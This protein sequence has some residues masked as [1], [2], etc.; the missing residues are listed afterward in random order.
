MIT[1]VFFSGYIC[2]LAFTITQVWVK[3]RHFDISYLYNTSTYGLGAPGSSPGTGRF[4]PIT[5]FSNNKNLA[6]K[7]LLE[8][9]CFPS[10]KN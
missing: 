6:C 10:Y 4:S 1:Q 5:D 7:L 8:D 2:L 9:R 3:V